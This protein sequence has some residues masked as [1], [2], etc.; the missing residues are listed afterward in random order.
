MKKKRLAPSQLFGASPKFGPSLRSIGTEDR[1]RRIGGI[2]GQMMATFAAEDGT[3][4]G[5]VTFFEELT[6]TVIRGRGRL[7]GAPLDVVL[8]D[9]ALCL[10]PS[11]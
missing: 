5:R 7:T 11:S 10:R 4:S 9:F 2:H 6:S 8:V 3:A 1:A